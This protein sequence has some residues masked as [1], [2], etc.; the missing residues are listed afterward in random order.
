MRLRRIMNTQHNFF[1]TL[2]VGSVLGLG[3]SAFAANSV[4]PS[5][6]DARMAAALKNYE[7]RN[8]SKGAAPMH[9]SHTGRSHAVPKKHGMPADAQPKASDKK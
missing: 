9:H 6:R 4:E 5:S 8:S 2:L 1:R 3:A 7:L